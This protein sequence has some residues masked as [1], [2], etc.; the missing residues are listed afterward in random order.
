MSSVLQK[1]LMAEHCFIIKYGAIYKVRNG[2][3]MNNIKKLSI[4]IYPYPANIS[5]SVSVKNTLSI[6]AFNWRVRL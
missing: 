4:H 2:L 6:R 1:V 3:K 5:F